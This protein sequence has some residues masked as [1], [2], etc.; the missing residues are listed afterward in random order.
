MNESASVVLQGDAPLRQSAQLAHLRYSAFSC[1]SLAL[2]YPDEALREAMSDGSL[3]AQMRELEALVGALGLHDAMREHCSSASEADHLALR[4][5]YTRL[6][7]T[8]N[9][10]K[11]NASAYADGSYDADAL[12]KQAYRRLGITR[13]ADARESFGHIAYAFDFL[14]YLAYME[15]KAWAD[16]DVASAQDWRGEELDFWDIHVRAFASAFAA[17][18]DSATVSPFYRLMAD[19]LTQASSCDLFAQRPR[20]SLGS[21]V[22]TSHQVKDLG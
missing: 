9:L 18:L 19:A 1:F 2:L 12:I 16:G 7:Y 13:A 15:L 20:T 10:L 5:E 21:L 11:A 3:A 6:F 8:G 4:M 17:A 14:G 22:A